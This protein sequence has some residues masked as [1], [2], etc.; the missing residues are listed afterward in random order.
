MSK[1]IFK[2]SVKPVEVSIT[3]R[4][5]MFEKDASY[6]LLTEGASI[7]IVSGPV[8]ELIAQFVAQLSATLA[9]EV[10]AVDDVPSSIGARAP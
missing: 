8:H 6:V 5:V 7:D 10:G 3:L 9:S 2:Q 1:I 4:G